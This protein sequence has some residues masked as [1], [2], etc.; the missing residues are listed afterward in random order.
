MALNIKRIRRIAVAVLDIENAVSQFKRLFNIDPFDWGEV[1]ELKYKWV[2]F[3]F[4]TDGANQCSMEFLSPM[5]DPNGTTLIGKFIR[6]RGEGLYMVTLESE[7]TDVKAS[8]AKMREM[9]VEPSYEN[10]H[11]LDGP[12]Y[13]SWT[14]TYI[15]PKDTHGVLF[16]LAHIIPKLP[17]HEGELP[18]FPK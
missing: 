1:P 14:E 11:F 6:K 2:A 4:G 13:K 15:S 10:A 17:K 9:G 8:E 12:D 18:K 5:N 7:E 3:R 16:V